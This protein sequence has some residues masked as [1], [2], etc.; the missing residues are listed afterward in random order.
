MSHKHLEMSMICIQLDTGSTD[1][2]SDRNQRY[3]LCMHHYSNSRNLECI[4]LGTHLL[5]MKYKWLDRVSKKLHHISTHQGNHYTCSNHMNYSQLG[6]RNQPQVRKENYIL[7]NYKVHCIEYI[8]LSTER[9][10]SYSSNTQ[11]C[12]HILHQHMNDS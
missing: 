7:S 4:A 1:Q 3:K 2:H 12:I 9:K 8:Y 10:Q 5:C 6:N 11:D